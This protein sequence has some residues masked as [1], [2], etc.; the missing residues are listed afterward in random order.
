LPPRRPGKAAILAHADDH[1][2]L[3]WG[4]LELYQT[5]FDLRYLR[6][7]LDL[8]KQLLARF[9]DAEGGAL[10]FTPDDGER[11]L[12][13]QKDFYDGATP[14]ANSVA[15]LVLL[16]L[17]AITGEP[18][19]EERA[20]AIAQAAAP[21]VQRMPHAFTQLLVAHDFAIGPACEIK[22][23]DACSC[24]LVGPR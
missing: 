23:S 2:F 19:L 15:M 18:D 6:E 22:G 8:T 11:L 9:W 1:A 21:V 20:A 7:A 14:S 16:Q 12:V 10:F 24:L 3:A 13:R 4:L 17:A 5:T